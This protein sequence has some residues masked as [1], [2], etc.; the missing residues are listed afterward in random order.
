ME[1]YRVEWFVFGLLDDGTIRLHADSPD[2]KRI[3]RLYPGGR[4]GCDGDAWVAGMSPIRSALGRFTIDCEMWFG[5]W[6]RMQ[7]R[8]REGKPKR[9]VTPKVETERFLPLNMIRKM[10]RIGTV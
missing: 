9:A 2:T 10:R 5:E 3:F 8:V 4:N 1:I 7:D 6:K